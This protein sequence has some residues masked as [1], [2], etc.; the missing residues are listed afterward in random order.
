MGGQCPL[1]R[2]SSSVSGVV[3]CLEMNQALESRAVK[4][5]ESSIQIIR[6]L[7]VLK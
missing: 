2:T 6:P 7:L 4:G 3:L 1:K 5:A